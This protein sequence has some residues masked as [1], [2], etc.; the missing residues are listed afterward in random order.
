MKP[1][2]GY[3]PI[4]VGLLL[5]LVLG[6]P[7]QPTTQPALVGFDADRAYRNAA[8]VV[9]EGIPRV[10]GS[11]SHDR[12]GEFI[13][14]RLAEFGRLRVE[15]EPFDWHGLSYTNILATIDEGPDGSDP[16]RIYLSA[17][18]DSRPG[19]PGAVD[20]ASGVGILLESIRIL[21]GRDWDKTLVFAFWDGEEDGLVGS[22]HHVRG[23]SQDEQ[24]SVLAMISL[25][26]PGWQGGSPVIH[27]FGKAWEVDAPRLVPFW[28]PHLVIASADRAGEP[29]RI[30]DPWISFHYQMGVRNMRV[31]FSSDDGPFLEAGIPAIFLSNSSFIQ[32]FPHYH[33]PADT[34]EQVGED[35]LRQCGKTVI[36]ATEALETL[37]E[38][39]QPGSDVYL[40]LGGFVFTDWILRGMMLLAMVPALL[41]APSTRVDRTCTVAL[42]LLGGVT[43]FRLDDPFQPCLAMPLL[44]AYPLLRVRRSYLL[45]AISLAGLLPAFT[46][47]LF[48]IQ[49]RVLFGEDAP[50]HLSP[51]DWITLTAA[52]AI[53]LFR[54]VQAEKLLRKDATAV[55]A[56]R[57]EQ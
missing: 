41:A 2:L 23:L 35:A 17:H 14:T 39:P 57:T 12:A 11:P 40:I 31:P 52:P 36:A 22:R 25:D 42:L 50:I 47:A 3:L 43:V 53:F 33:G 51:L 28:L 26:M 49:V 21:V 24:D 29:L 8:E 48:L 19:T 32:F 4:S 9:G 1:Y 16:S 37:E 5:A 30:G 15:T 44:L 27:T 56:G 7:P 18:Y 55:D 6:R 34:M 10:P 46:T 38:R 20:N 45:K 54:A 13:R